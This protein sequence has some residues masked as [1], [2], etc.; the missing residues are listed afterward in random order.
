MI[1]KLLEHEANCS[2]LRYRAEVAPVCASLSMHR[3]LATSQED[4]QVLESFLFAARAIHRYFFPRPRW[5]ASFK[6]QVNT[7]PDP[8]H[9][10]D[11]DEPHLPQKR[12][13]VSIRPLSTH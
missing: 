11:E 5:D 7:R 8:V 1:H 4:D 9:V 10:R 12:P 13:G 3:S 2:E 6:V